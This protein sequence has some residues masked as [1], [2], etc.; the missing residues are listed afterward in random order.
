MTAKGVE[1]TA[2]YVYNRLVSLNEVGG[3]PG[4][5][6]VHARGGARLQ[7]RPAGPLALCPVAAV[8]PRHQAQRGRPR[9]DQ[10][11][12]RDA[13]GLVPPCVER[14]SRLQRAA[15]ARRDDDQTIPDANEEYLLYQTLVG[16][17]PLE[18]YAR[19]R[20]TPT[21]VAA[22]PGLHAQGPARG[23]GAHELDQPQRRV[24]RGHPG[25]RRP[26]PRRGHQPRRSSTTSGPSSGGSA[27]TACYNSLSQTLLKLASPG[28]PGHVPG[29]RALGLQP[30]GPRQ[31]PAGRLSAPSANAPCPQTSNRN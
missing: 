28:V 20:N 31:P 29:D 15:S 4:R 12:L 8:H 1:D 2:F 14:W 22:N 3:E 27:T 7:P 10:R 24:R 23:Q 9:P 25:V 26:H 5:F 19:P 18:P 13:R 16:A 17:W 11:P 6:G 30:G 21:F